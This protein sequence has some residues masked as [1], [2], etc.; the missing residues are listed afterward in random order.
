MNNVTRRVRR[1]L[2]LIPYL[3]QR[4]KVSLKHAARELGCP[5]REILKDLDWILMCGVPPYQPDDYIGVYRNKDEVEI[6]FAEG[7]DRPVALSLVEALSV[8]ILLETLAATGDDP[9]AETCT[10]LL[11]KIEQ[12]L[13]TA[14]LV[15][16]DRR[17][18]VRPPPPALR[19]RL[20]QLRKA[21]EERT[22]LDIEYYSAS[23]ETV[24]TRPV[25]PYGLIHHLDGHYLIAWCETRAQVLSF[26]VDRIR[27]LGPAGRRFDKPTDFDLGEFKK[28][29]HFFPSGKGREAVVH[30]DAAVAAQA[31]ETCPTAALES[32]SDG[33]VTARIVVET[34]SWFLN[35]ML[36]FGDRAR[37]L[38]PPTLIA[39]LREHVQSCRARLAD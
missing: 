30:F 32:H 11:A 3:K 17:V 34:S 9:L 39:A 20:S 10:R 29:K 13:A 33:S 5:R 6:A 8:K 28:R 21:I 38:E 4:R 24:K 19:K 35:W 2:T 31:L 23:S 18:R 16:A 1:I 37:I 27:A 22:V 36:R 26:R 14:G 7:F 15:D 12:R 25:R